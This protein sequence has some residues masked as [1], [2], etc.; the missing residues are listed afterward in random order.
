MKTVLYFGTNYCRFIAFFIYL[1]DIL[2]ELKIG[3]INL[4]FNRRDSTITYNNYIIRYINLCRSE[5]KIKGIK[6]YAT[7][8]GNFETYDYLRLRNPAL[9]EFKTTEAFIKHILPDNE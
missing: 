4:S 5:D 7:I 1:K 2:K 9:K 3:N 6:A 8:Y